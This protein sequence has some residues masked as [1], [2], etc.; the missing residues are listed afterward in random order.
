MK[1]VSGLVALHL[2]CLVL[3][4][5][6]FFLYVN[7]AGA[8]NFRSEQWALI[9][10]AIVY[11][12]VIVTNRPSSV[13]E[14]ALK[15]GL[16]PRVLKFALASVILIMLSIPFLDSDTQAVTLIGLGCLAMGAGMFLFAVKAT[17]SGE[18]SSSDLGN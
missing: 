9:A 16:G 2:L 12:L 4:A 10:S 7:S 13:Y 17:L 5:P 8:G 3:C 14:G 1:G 15:F 18:P 11:G 6:M